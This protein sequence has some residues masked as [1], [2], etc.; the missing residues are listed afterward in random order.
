MWVLYSST[1]LEIS[2]KFSLGSVDRD[3]VK[4][5]PIASEGD[6][7]G[8]VTIKF[9][10]YWKQSSLRHTGNHYTL[11]QG[12]FFFFSVK[13]TYEHIFVCHWFEFDWLSSKTQYKE[14]KLTGISDGQ[15]KKEKN[16]M[17]L[18]ILS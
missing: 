2:S 14:G 5:L 8:G 16:L 9:T 6:N 1:I 13:R 11:D 7:N 18:E 10:A 3:E 4:N 17:L 15:E 12:A